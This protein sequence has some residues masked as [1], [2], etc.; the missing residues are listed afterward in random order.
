MNNKVKENVLLIQ[1]KDKRE[2]ASLAIISLDLNGWNQSELSRRSGVT[3]GTISKIVNTGEVNQVNMLKVF[4]TLGLIKAG[5]DFK[6]CPFCGNIDPKIKD[7]CRT[8]DEMLKSTNKAVQMLGDSILRS[9][10]S[11][12]ESK[13]GRSGASSGSK[14][15]GCT[16]KKAM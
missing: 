5:H 14:K 16:E 12:K 10:G 2:I 7:A 13:K 3:P 8:L 11:Y 4:K 9:I 6:K 15:K 1:D